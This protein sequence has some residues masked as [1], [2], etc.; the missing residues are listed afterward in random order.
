MNELIEQI[1][2]KVAKTYDDLLV[3]MLT[4]CGIDIHDLSKEN[5]ARVCR[6]T[7]GWYDHWLVDGKYAF[8]I[9]SISESV[10]QS[11]D[12]SSYTFEVSYK[13]EIIEKM[14]GQKI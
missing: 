10:R 12:D 8:T 5:L 14:K 1:A 3:E 2:G 4:A 9:T 13:V 7:T 6:V 11:E